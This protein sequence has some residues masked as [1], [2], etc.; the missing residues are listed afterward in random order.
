MNNNDKCRSNNYSSNVILQGHY[1]ILQALHESLLPLGL[2]AL[3]PIMIHC[4]S[5]KTYNAL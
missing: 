5:V 4:V 3:E 2:M 1:R